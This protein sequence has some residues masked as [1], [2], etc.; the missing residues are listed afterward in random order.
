MSS[1]KTASQIQIGKNTAKNSEIATSAINNY[2]ISGTGGSGYAVT[3]TVTGVVVTNSSFA[4]TPGAKIGNSNSF[5]KVYGAGFIANTVVVVNANNVPS[6]NVT[7]TSSSELRVVLPPIANVA[8]VT[9]NVLNPSDNNVTTCQPSY[10]IGLLVV[11]GGGSGGWSRGGGGGAGGMLFSNTTVTAGVSYPIAVGSG[12]AARTPLSPFTPTSVPP[13]SSGATGAPSRFHVFTQCG[14]GGGGSGQG[15]C[16]V[17][18]K[19]QLGGS[20]GGGGNQSIYVSPGGAADVGLAIGSPGVGV[21]GTFGFPG[22]T[23]FGGGNP[24]FVGNAGGGGG[25]GAAG[26]NAGPSFAGPGG[27]G[28]RWPY[29]RTYYAGGGGG[30]ASTLVPGSSTG[31]GGCGGGGNGGSFPQAGVCSTGGGGGGGGNGCGTPGQSSG[32]GGPGVVILAI[33]TPVYPTVLAPGASVSTSPF[34]PGY[35]LL[36]WATTHGSNTAY[37][38]IA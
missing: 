6:T 23:D 15:G 29:N 26:G 31:G 10:Q 13:G 5:V 2:Y 20:G 24:P 22:G 38:F 25:A 9:F 4:N 16:G 36:K 30:T 19:G 12:G 8:T 21:A 18:K 37:T 35:T 34:S 27:I 3:T 11:A 14:G 1:F 28:L 32:A 7:Y 33:P 17:C